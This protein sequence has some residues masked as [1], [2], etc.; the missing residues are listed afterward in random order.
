MKKI[1]SIMITLVLIFSL[2]VVS[3]SASTAPAGQV[4]DVND[5]FE[6]DVLDATLIQYYA[7]DLAQLDETQHVF[8]DVDLDRQVTI[9]DATHIQKYLVDE[10]LVSTIGDYYNYDMETN[11]FYSDYESGRAM[12]GV[13]VTFTCNVYA[14]SPILRY[15][16]YVNNELVASD[17]HSNSLTYTFD[18]AD[19]YE[20]K[21][22]AVACFSAGAFN[23][24]F[25]VVEPYESDLPLIKTLY[26]TG[27]EGWG[28]ICYNRSGIQY[29]VEGIGGS[30]TYQYKFM[31][32]RPE[33]FSQDAKMVTLFQ[34]YSD[35]NTFELENLDYDELDQTPGFPQALPCTL[36]VYVM[37]S[38]GV[39]VSR[40]VEFYY[41]DRPIG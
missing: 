37:D 38:N 11:D 3:A 13:P 30:G 31:L 14:G 41:Q 36:V 25:E 28:T 15:E 20:V 23:I 16:L 27:T 40:A 39:E 19:T 4:G 5:D 8:A 32:I 18:K 35:D 33:D 22:V 24:D 21:M 26:L 9:I 29:H 17:E 1:I 6:I 2:C 7:A 12:A 34:D 10:P